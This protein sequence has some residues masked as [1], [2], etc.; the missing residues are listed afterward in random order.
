MTQPDV[1]IGLVGHIDH[2]KT[3]LTE[4]L[5][6]V[7]TDKHSEE[8]K[9]GITIKLGYADTTLYKCTKCK[10]PQCYTSLPKCPNCEGKCEKTR[11]IS[12]VDAP[13][14][15]TLMATMLSGAAIIDGAVL[16]IAANEPCPSPQTKEHLMALDIIGKD[17]IVIVQNKIDLVTKEQALEN[18]KQIKKFVKGTVA[19]S[20]PIIP[21]SAQK[22]QNIDAVI[23]AIEKFIPTP[24]RDSKSAAKMLI[25]RSFDINKPGTK[26]ADLNGGILGGTLLAGKLKIGQKIEI[27]PGVKLGGGKWQPVETEIES[28]FAAG[29]P[30]KSL[31]AGGSIGIGTKLDPAMTK[32]DNLSGNLLGETGKLPKL[33]TELVIEPNLLKR[34]VGLKDE[35]D[36]SPI[37]VG[38]PLMLTVG[39]TITVGV[40]T[41]TDGKTATLKLKLPVCPEKGEKIVISRQIEHRWRLVGY[42]VIK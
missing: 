23:M 10:E 16:V 19:E 8:L 13:G 1:S 26:P 38:E 24:K 11:T 39:C 36:V 42:G 32:S 3:T 5:S 14:H 33:Q 21:I 2:G 30:E 27:L 22:R 25:A 12:F 29:K 6:G 37:R 40:P 31:H 9:K 7:W 15:E 17:K 28:L 41:K 20:S 35:I 34:V 18:Y 4:A